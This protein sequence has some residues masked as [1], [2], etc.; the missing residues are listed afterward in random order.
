MEPAK[1]QGSYIVTLWDEKQQ[2]VRQ[3]GEPFE[4]PEGAW[5]FMER[6]NSLYP[7]LNFSVENKHSGWKTESKSLKI[8]LL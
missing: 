4:S 1:Q 5:E 2:T 6:L 8:A 7:R 3:I